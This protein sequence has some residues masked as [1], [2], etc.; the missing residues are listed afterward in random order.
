M[1]ILLLFNFLVFDIYQFPTTEDKD[2]SLFHFSSSSWPHHTRM[3]QPSPNFPNYIVALARF[4]LLWLC[5]FYSEVWNKVNFSFP[6]QMIILCVVNKGLDFYLLSF[7]GIY[8]LKHIG[9]FIN[10]ILSKKFASEFSVWSLC[11][12]VVILVFPFSIIMGIPF[13]SP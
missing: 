1:P 4:T 9:Y 13:S 3:N 8:T 12:W 10:F 11:L 2:L 6:A 5:Q 7:L